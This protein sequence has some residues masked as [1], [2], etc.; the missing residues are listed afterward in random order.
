MLVQ[1]ASLPPPQCKRIDESIEGSVSSVHTRS[2]G[3]NR[4]RT[5]LACLFLTLAPL[6][7]FAQSSTVQRVNIVRLGIYEL[8]TRNRAT[9]EILQDRSWEV[10]RKIRQVHATS[11]IPA[12]PCLSFGFEYVIVGA[13]T[14]AVIPIK[15]V[16]KFPGEGLYDP[17]TRKTTLRSETLVGRTIGAMHLRSYT[18][19]KR[20]ELVPGVWTFQLWY[21]NQKLAEQTFTVTTSQQAQPEGKCEESPVAVLPVRSGA[22]KALGRIRLHASASLR[23]WHRQPAAIT[24]VALRRLQWFDRTEMGSASSTRPPSLNLVATLSS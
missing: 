21:Q 19:D 12:Q 22:D 6:S 15:M 1:D 11:V 5:L 16:T 9:D 14:G 4:M 2:L 7:V 17:D 23:S 18:F 20:W 10:V 3:N 13:P 8:E 24:R